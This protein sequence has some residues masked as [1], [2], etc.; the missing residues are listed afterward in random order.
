MALTGRRKKKAI[1]VLAIHFLLKECRKRKI[2]RCWIK[3]W[4]AKHDE[5]GAYFNLVC[6]LEVD[7]SLRNKNT[8]RM[9]KAQLIGSR[10]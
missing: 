8:L 3:P 6:E 2:R 9:T 5:Q 7:G 4:I 10:D 1:A